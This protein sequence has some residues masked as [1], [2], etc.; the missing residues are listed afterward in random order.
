MFCLRCFVYVEADLWPLA[1]V[2]VQ[3]VGLELTRE[4]SSVNAPEALVRD[5]APLVV[6]DIATLPEMNLWR[7]L[8]FLGACQQQGSPH[9]EHLDS[10]L[11][12]GDAGT[13]VGERAT[14]GCSFI[15]NPARLREGRRN[16]DRIEPLL[17][18]SNI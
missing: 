16:C 4:A 13:E 5:F 6:D 18:L 12:R 14:K 17:G 7:P 2:I 10:A 3:M 1:Y 9:G 8:Y 15:C 11:E